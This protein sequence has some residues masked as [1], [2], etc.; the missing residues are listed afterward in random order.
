MHVM[1]SNRNP[2]ETVEPW[3]VRESILQIGVHAARDLGRWQHAL[4]LNAEVAASARRRGAGPHEIAYQRFNDQGPL[5]G[6]GQLD[7]AE[8]LLRECQQVFE[9]YQDVAA[10]GRVLTAR[11][12][13]ASRRGHHAAAITFDKAAL[14]LT[15]AQPDPRALAIAH[16]C[17]AN[18]LARAG[19]DPSGRLAHRLAAALIRH[20]TG[21]H[22]DESVRALASDL[23]TLGDRTLLP[24]TLDD[25][26]AQVEQVE[27]VHFADLIGTLTPVPERAQAA[28]DEFVH[29]VRTLLDS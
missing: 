23:H 1:P 19:T 3:D 15:Y 11:A 25:L 13:L 17:L 28:L 5:V 18:H 26:A 6:L 7:E 10:L 24:A 14:R 12:N 29:A 2:N 22:R 21:A 8:A 4:D 16:A 9:D 20:L 27:G